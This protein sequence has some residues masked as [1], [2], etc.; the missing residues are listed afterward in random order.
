MRLPGRLA[1]TALVPAL[2]LA[3]GDQVLLPGVPGEL[4]ERVSAFGGSRSQFGV[5]ALGVTPIVSAYWIVEVAALLVAPWSH[6]RRSPEGRATLDRAARV[7]M[8]VLASVQAFAMATSLQVLGESSD[9]SISVPIVSVTLVA[10]VALELAVARLISRHGVL[11]GF[12]ALTAAGLVRRLVEEAPGR[13][14]FLAH[15]G[16]SASTMA[17]PLP[18][19][20][21]LIG[22]ALA[23]AATVGA[24]WAA[25]RGG[26][27]LP[28]EGAI[29]V[30]AGTPYRDARRVAIHPWI[31]VPSSSFQPYLTA[32]ALVAFPRTLENLWRPAHG[33]VALFESGARTPILAALTLALMLLFSRWMHR[34]AEIADVA[35]RV[36]RADEGALET[37][38]R[39][40]LRRTLLPSSLF[41]VT[42]V[43][44]GMATKVGSLSLA[45]LTVVAMD[46]VY[47][48][49]AAD[50]EP[51]FV[52]VWDVWR[53]SGV[54]IV[55]ARLAE[56][57]IAVQ[58]RGMSVLGFW[59]VFA[60]YAPAE[61]WVKQG[62]SERATVLLR[63]LL[64][65]A[66]LAPPPD[67]S[68][69]PVVAATDE[70][71]MVHRT[72]ML[73]ASGC[74]ALGAA[75]IAFLR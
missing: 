44:A 40:A 14:G 56:S 58:T 27:L 51:D 24:T 6:L 25:L 69:R 2:V 65:G 48:V 26:G 5:F 75:M 1:V 42:I 8:L 31:P 20:R 11:N 62:D 47:A 13:L 66:P 54:P 57:G 30:V 36:V 39:E 50:A 3:C 37:G 15:H 52:R 12:V 41:F 67:A 23:A 29:D 17:S 16:V 73:A 43:V 59:Q 74:V 49:R 60:P 28:R 35:A 38:A 4:F 64:A 34:P 71:T 18:E 9:F 55:V 45:F 32:L 72:K 46:L 22:A 19:P 68:I 7:L 33:L 53:V 21:I 63:Q 70:W 10:G 61:L